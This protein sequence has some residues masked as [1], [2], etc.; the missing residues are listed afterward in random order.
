MSRSRLGLEAER[1]GSRLGL[2]HEGLV[3]IPGFGLMR[4]H[5]STTRP[6]YLAAV[7]KDASKSYVAFLLLCT[8]VQDAGTEASGLCPCY[9]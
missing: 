8:I 2:G 3:S 5:V 7:L 6:T 4:K 9:G 1:L